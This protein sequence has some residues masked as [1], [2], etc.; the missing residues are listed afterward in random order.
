MRRSS[1]PARLPP[2]LAYSSLLLV[3]LLVR[4]R[5]VVSVV[6][7]VE[8]TMVRRGW[9]ALG[10]PSVT[11]EAGPSKPTSGQRSTNGRAG[12]ARSQSV[13]E[14]DKVFLGVLVTKRG[15]FLPFSVRASIRSSKARSA[16]LSSPSRWLRSIGCGLIVPVILRCL[17]NSPPKS[18]AAC[19]SS[20]E[21]QITLILGGFAVLLKLRDAINGMRYRDGVDLVREPL[22]LLGEELPVRPRKIAPDTFRRIATLRHL[23]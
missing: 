15:R 7:R 20:C 16:S 10:R 19:S 1:R 5:H 8:S 18:C 3:C 21:L 13:Y 4:L 17:V 11:P 9:S 2:G 14:I 22:A 12:S 23:R 6:V